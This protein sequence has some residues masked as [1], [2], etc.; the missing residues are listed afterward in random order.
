MHRLLQ[1]ESWEG[2]VNINCFINSPRSGCR[3]S[4]MLCP[5]SAQTEPRG[6]TNIYWRTRDLDQHKDPSTLRSQGQTQERRGPMAC[7]PQAS[8]SGSFPAVQVRVYWIQHWGGNHSRA[9]RKPTYASG[10]EEE[11]LVSPMLPSSTKPPPKQHGQKPAWIRV[12]GCW[13]GQSS[14]ICVRAVTSPLSRWGW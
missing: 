7:K 13:D 6:H 9:I 8:G 12:T 3:E 5:S 14:K 10:V 1:G 4:K 2:W 11:G